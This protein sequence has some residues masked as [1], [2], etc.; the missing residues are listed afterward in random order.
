MSTESL[1]ILY[2]LKLIPNSADVIGSMLVNTLNCTLTTRASKVNLALSGTVGTTVTLASNAPTLTTTDV[3]ISSTP[4][5]EPS[6]GSSYTATVQST[7]AYT[8]GDHY[9]AT[10]FTYPTTAGNFNVQSWV[11]KTGVGKWQTECNPYLPKDASKT[12]KITMRLIWSR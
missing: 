8:N 7:A 10:E 9:L 1:Q 3:D 4:L 2:V 5:G 12:L 6:G 11:F